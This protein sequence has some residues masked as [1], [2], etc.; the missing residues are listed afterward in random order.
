MNN[1]DNVKAIEPIHITWVRATNYSP[2]CHIVLEKIHYTDNSIKRNIRII[3]DFKRPYY[4]TKINYRN[5][6]QNKEREALSK[7]TEYF[8]TQSDLSLNINKSLGRNMTNTSLRHALNSP[9][10]YG[11]S[12]S[13]TAYLRYM[14]GKKYPIKQ[15]KLRYLSYDLETS[16]GADKDASIIIA[17]LAGDDGSITV[18]IRKDFVANINNVIPA[19]K[20]KE[21]ELISEYGYSNILKADTVKYIIV[22]NEAELIKSLSKTMF[23]YQPD[24]VAAWNHDFDVNKLIER[25]QYL[26][27][28]IADIFSHPDIPKAI[29]R[30]RFI[31][32]ARSKTTVSGNFRPL[33]PSEQWHNVHAT[34]GFMWLDAMCVY[35]ALRSQGQSL[36]SYSLDAIASKHLNIG[37][38]EL[39]ETEHL[40]NYETHIY[41]Q[42]KRPL[43]YIVYA[44]LDARLMILIE[45]QTKDLTLR[46]HTELAGVDVEST[47]R[48]TERTMTMFSLDQLEKGYILG[49]AGTEPDEFPLDTLPLGGWP[50][51]LS[52]N[53][54]H[55]KGVKVLEDMPDADTNLY[56]NIFTVDITSGYP[57][58]TRA[59]NVSKETT[60]TEV[61]RLDNV[62][63]SYDTWRYQNMNLFAGHITSIDYVVNMFKWPSLSELDKLIDD[64]E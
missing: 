2:D 5:H 40:S 33:S 10:V 57:N 45:Q 50:L 52:N 25:C 46:L 54:H 62:N 49:T 64:L 47:K 13:S 19:I 21:K 16:V 34:S 30:F 42:E 24:V 39:D 31:E 38:L 51:T 29:R 8:S 27:L 53:L 36:A 15:S 59:M 12:L 63:V 58:G 20:A 56:T 11:A 32:G 6:K 43:E 14:Y 28:N 22:D 37:K 3:R 18:I 1:L 4:I 9:Y 60:L 7:L 44:A 48:S 23:D 26:N 41:M 61:C 17:S 35:R 55:Q